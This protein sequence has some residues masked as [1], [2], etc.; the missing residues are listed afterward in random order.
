M[1][2]IFKRLFS[3]N[4]KGPIEFTNAPKDLTE[5]FS[6]GK[7]TVFS[8][9]ECPYCDSAKALLEQLK[10]SYQYIECDEHELTREQLDQLKKLSGIRTFP[11]IFIGTVSVGGFGDLKTKYQ[12]GALKGILES[13][14]IGIK[15]L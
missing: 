6:K 7:I 11:N 5:L 12:S 4:K 14:D 2:T 9:S 10:L 13:Q 8:K 1:I 15:S 3:T